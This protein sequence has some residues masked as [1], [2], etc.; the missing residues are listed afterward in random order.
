MEIQ[1]VMLRRGSSV[2]L[3]WLDADRVK[4]GN[5]VRLKEIEG[6]WTVDEVYASRRETSQVNR[7]WNVGGVKTRRK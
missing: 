2:L 1:Q 3:C 7:D 6:W 4:R 5:Q